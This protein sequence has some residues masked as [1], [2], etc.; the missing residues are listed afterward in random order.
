MVAIAIQA[1]DK[2]NRLEYSDKKSE[3]GLSILYLPHDDGSAELHAVANGQPDIVATFSRRDLDLA[4]LL[5]TASTELLLVRAKVAQDKAIVRKAVEV[6][7]ALY[8]G[9]HVSAEQF[10]AASAPRI[11]SHEA[12]SEPFK[13]VPIDIDGTVYDRL[14][15]KTRLISTNDTDILPIVEEF[16]GPYIKKDD[17]LFIS[18]KTLTVTQGRVVNMNDINVTRLARFFARHVGNNFGT[19]DF[20]GYG[21]GTFHAMQL[22]I[23]ETGY[24]RA[25]FAAIVAV[26]TRPLGIHGLFYKICGTRAKSIDCPMSF[27]VLEYAHTGKLAPHNSSGEARRI[28]AKLGCEV[29]IL[30]SNYRGAFSLG[31]STRKIS[32]EFIGKAFRDNPMGQGDE[33]TPF[34]IVRKA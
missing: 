12:A 22:F 24:A 11:V 16:A 32:E 6:L 7:F 17:I 14:L 3:T 19:S 15:I 9:E 13:S 5:Y 31:K 33:M 18:E 29:V 8:R 10:A 25:I 27:V 30:D 34:C 23:E 20:R 4:H 1:T 28:R 21:H 26:L 2:E